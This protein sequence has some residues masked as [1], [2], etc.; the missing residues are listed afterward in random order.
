MNTIITKICHNCWKK[1]PSWTE[2]RKNGGYRYRG[3]NVRAHNSRTCSRICSREYTRECN[4]NRKNGI[5]TI[6]H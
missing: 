6:K 2:K 4:R 3:R 1:Y 5:K